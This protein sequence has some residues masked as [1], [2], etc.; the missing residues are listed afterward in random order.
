MK[1]TTKSIAIIRV[2]SLVILCS[3]L[4][5]SSTAEKPINL[6][7]D[8]LSRMKAA[9]SKEKIPVSIWTYDIAYDENKIVEQAHERV[10]MINSMSSSSTKTKSADRSS[11]LIPSG[12]DTSKLSENQLFIEAKRKIYENMYTD[13]NALSAKND[14]EL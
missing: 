9:D 5:I 6:S 7:A 3:A 10:D 1:K 4:S 14:S 13:A 11:E 8:L 2:L 12:G